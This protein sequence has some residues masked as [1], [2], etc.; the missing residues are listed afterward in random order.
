[1][2]PSSG[3]FQNLFYISLYTRSPLPDKYGDPT[4]TQQPAKRVCDCTIKYMCVV[5]DHT[6]GMHIHGN[7]LRM[8]EPQAEVSVGRANVV[9]Q[10]SDDIEDPFGRGPEQIRLNKIEK[11]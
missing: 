11:D 4:H 3:D 8:G 7:V 10:K 9:G 1:M 5:M 6:G 2:F